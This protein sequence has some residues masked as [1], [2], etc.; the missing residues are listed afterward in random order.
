[1]ET[2]YRL[3]A[4]LLHRL[5]LA[6]GSFAASL[7]GQRGAA[8][9]WC[10]WAAR[11]RGDGR[12]VWLHAASVG[13]ALAAEPVVQRLCAALPA[14]TVIL[15]HTSPSVSGRD[16]LAGAHH[17]DY[18][19]LDEPRPVARVLDA[20]RPDLLLLSRGDLWPELLHQTHAR[21]VPV[22]VIGGVV[23]PRSRRLEWP[24]RAALRSTCAR[25]GY[26]GAVTEGDAARWRRMGV[27]A[28][29]VE[30]TGD[31]RH[32]HVLERL[33]NLG[34][35]ELLR[36]WKRDWT[37]VAG[38]VEREDEAVLLAAAAGLARDPAIR[39][40]L[41]P[42]DPT[43]RAVRRIVALAAARGLTAAAWPGVGAP[44]QEAGVLVVTARGLLA[45]LYLLGDV[46]YVGGGFRRGRLHAVAEP[47]VY[48]LPAVFGRH[49]HDTADAPALL[50]NGGGVAVASATE[51]LALLRRWRA[52]PAGLTAA[53]LRGRGAL[54]EGAAGRSAL[55]LLTL[56]GG[57]RPP[58]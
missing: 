25:L 13:E 47:A 23:R 27:P 56:I 37:V 44:T 26:V 50:A 28:E 41:V 3:V 43:E 53:G 14:L 55:V 10:A 20:L 40:L 35:L 8:A 51:L 24:A 39:W 17:V 36:P 19:P 18:L 57:G 5:P 42:H 49:W 6:L 21:G 1:M 32:D 34:P 30:I 45:D 46:A 29:R 38:S 48:G 7:A 11:E 4:R 31:P 2:T 9:R 16:G 12:L 52:T 33:A 54:V 15:T 22:A 58:A